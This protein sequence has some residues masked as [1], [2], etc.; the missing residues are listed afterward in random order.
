MATY[1]RREVHTTRV[2][3]LVPAPWPTGACWTEV[4]KAIW[5]ATKELREAGR[6][7]EDETPPDDWIWVTPGDSEVIVSYESERQAY[8][9]RGGGS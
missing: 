7:G 9:E 5:S 3:F 1:S 2:E 8:A 6:L 4:Q